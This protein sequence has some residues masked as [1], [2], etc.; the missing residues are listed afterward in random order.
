MK[1]GLL[2]GKRVVEE[3]HEPV[4]RKVLERS[5]MGV[6]ELARRRVVLADDV[7]QLLGLCGLGESGEPAQVEVGD[8]DVRTVSGEKLLSLLARDELGNAGREEA[9]QL[10][11][12]AL[13]RLQEPGVRDRNRSLVRERLRESHVLVGEGRNREADDHDDSDQHFVHEDRN[14]EHGPVRGRALV[15]VLRVESHIRDVEGPTRHRRSAG[16]GLP[17]ERMRVI[18]VVCH[19]RRMAV[20]R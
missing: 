20:V 15:T 10:R 14:A 13:D 2:D 11:A 16:R 9:S 8:R 12:L 6:D 7:D 1:L 18:P 4:A 19:V 17:V 5:R 3:D